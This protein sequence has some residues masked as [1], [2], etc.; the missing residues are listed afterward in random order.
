MTSTP[1]KEV[2]VVCVEWKS[3]V[4]KN[5]LAKPIEKKLYSKQISVYHTSGA[6][7]I[8]QEHN[9]PPLAK[10]LEAR[11]IL[12]HAGPKLYRRLRH[13]PRPV[14]ARERHL[15]LAAVQRRVPVLP[16]H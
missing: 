1:N 11:L 16:H 5:I 8:A 4:R 12:V 2:C 7:I 3:V 13:Q 9:L 15:K 10:R 14:P 6:T